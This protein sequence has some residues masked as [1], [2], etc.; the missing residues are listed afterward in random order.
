M[1]QRGV[2]TPLALLAV[3]ALVLANGF[4]V[5]TEFSIGRANHHA[6]LCPKCR[7]HLLADAWHP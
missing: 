5:A 6:S 2:S 1:S 3:V 4:F 7:A